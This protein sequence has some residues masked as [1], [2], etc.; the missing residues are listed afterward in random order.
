MGS[1]NDMRAGIIS[2]AQINLPLM[3]L[4]QGRIYPAQLAEFA[5][6]GRPQDLAYPR[7]HFR[8]IGGPSHT[9][10]EKYF[11][12]SMQSWSWSNKDYDEAW[13]VLHAFRAAISGKRIKVG[14]TAFR[15]SIQNMGQE[16]FDPDA[17][18]Y[19]ISSQFSIE[20]IE[21]S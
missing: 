7:V 5:V 20:L 1:M 14:D 17:T 4:I 13:E 11:P 21:G 16:V 15:P 12:I 19:Y 2:T 10:V 6:D 8:V 3:T 9:W 18:L